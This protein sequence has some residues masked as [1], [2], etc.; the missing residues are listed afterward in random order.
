MSMGDTESNFTT[1]KTHI[2]TL[3]NTE[4][5]FI[6]NPGNA[7]DILIA[8]GALKFFNDLGIK[9]SFGRFNQVFFNKHLIYG[10]GGNLVGT[11]VDCKSFLQNNHTQNIITLLPATIT[12]ED[13]L[14]SQLGEKITI[15][16]RD[17]ISYAYVKKFFKYHNNLH[18]SPDMALYLEKQ[19][20]TKTRQG[21]GIL[22]RT[23]SERN[24]KTESFSPENCDITIELIKYLT[25]INPEQIKNISE[26][27]LQFVSKFELV[28]TDKLHVAIACH[29]TETPCELYPNS[30]YKNE[31]VYNFSLKNSPY[32]KFIP[33]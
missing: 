1:L 9:F 26:S 5:I 7:G 21:L 33:F 30:Y 22:F 15:F 17:L 16:C 2:E 31:A 29:L 24:L 28:K 25:R 12:Q 10:G 18:T 19:N 23:D 4:I 27:L 20:Y 32:I 6:P 11:Y 3:R 14:I 8:H 13:F